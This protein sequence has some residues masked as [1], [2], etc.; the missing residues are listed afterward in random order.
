MGL[1]DVRYDPRKIN[2]SLVVEEGARILQ[3]PRSLDR[4]SGVVDSLS[5]KIRKLDNHLSGIVAQAKDKNDSSSKLDKELSIK[6]KQGILLIDKIENI[7][8]LISLLLAEV[9]S[10]EARL[11]V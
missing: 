10:L 7:Q 2:D 11:E 4:L 3:I 9:M 8:D 5:D 1:A 6:S